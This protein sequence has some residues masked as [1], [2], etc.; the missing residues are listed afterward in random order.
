M[1]MSP[2]AD[3]LR[4]EL[5]AAATGDTGL[6]RAAELL[7]TATAP[8]LRLLLLDVLADAAG[9]LG[10]LLST[11]VGV[12]L[13]PGGVAAFT[14]DSRPDL[15]PLPVDAGGDPAR[16]TLRLPQPLKEAAEQTAAATGQSVNAFLTQAVQRAVDRAL[17]RGFAHPSAAA[18][19]TQSRVSGWARS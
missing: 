15:E 18:G 8:G 4:A 3:R 5:V 9:E 14:A 6:Q 7:A 2:Y 10:A 19:R 16:L 1:E 11:D 17:D 12:R 13:A